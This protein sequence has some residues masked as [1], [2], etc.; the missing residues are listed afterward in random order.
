MQEKVENEKHWPYREIKISRVFQEQLGEMLYQGVEWTV[1]S[2]SI[3]EV[4]YE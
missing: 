2:S 3:S 1:T 4:P